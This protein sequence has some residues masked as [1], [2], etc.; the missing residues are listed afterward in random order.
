MMSE[1][2]K[3][4][5]P[6]LPTE[7]ELR[8]LLPLMGQHEKAQLLAL[9][10]AKKEKEGGLAELARMVPTARELLE[11]AWR[12]EAVKTDDPAEFFA[13]ARAHHDRWQFHLRRLHAGKPKPRTLRETLTFSAPGADWDEAHRLA[14][15]DGFP[16][17]LAAPPK[18][19]GNPMGGE[20]GLLQ[21]PAT[22]AN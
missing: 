21:R 3:P 17:P 9:L 11:M 16:D 18:P 10:E 19:A 8:R 14:T 13:A 2:D 7:A 22:K 6:E 4:Y 1:L 12:T 15:E 5:P 20:L